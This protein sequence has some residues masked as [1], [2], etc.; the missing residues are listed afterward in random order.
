MAKV[1]K[2]KDKDKEPEQVK[3]DPVGGQAVMEGVLMRSKDYF[4]VAVRK[5]DGSMVVKK[6]PVES[7]TKRAPW[8][9]PFVRGIVVLYESLQLGIDA[10][11]FSAN[12]SLEG[13]GEQ[14]LSKRSM[15]FTMIPT[16]IIAIAFFVGL[17]YLLSYL[18]GRWVTAV[19]ESQILFNIVDG[20][21]RIA[22][23]VGY[24]WIISLSKEIKRVFAYHGAEHKTIAGGEEGAGD[25][26]LEKSR[27]AS[28]FH[29]R[30]GTSFIIIVLLVIILMHTIIFSIFPG[31]NRLQNIVI[32]ILLIPI[33]AG[34]TYEIIRLSA[35]F[36]GNWLL[37]A[38]TAPGLW[39]QRITTREPTEGMLEVAL[40]SMSLCLDKR[41]ER[42]EPPEAKKT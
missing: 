1:E 3:I 2:S 36:P 8:K 12:V 5:K 38:F 18:L 6:E 30:C 26:N 22:L 28:R 4:C 15:A 10:L 24:I 31:L 7:A 32:R 40:T 39:M 19:S 27:Q 9:W 11:T 41:F 37:R 34:I 23:V 13:E 35:K 14:R 21:L 25:A 17:P 42:I 20:I 33:V 29:R 16:L